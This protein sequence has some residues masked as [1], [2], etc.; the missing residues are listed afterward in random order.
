MIKS[1]TVTNH[2]GES[3]TLELTRPEQSGLV[4]KGIDGLGPVKANINNTELATS[5]I[6]LFNSARLTERNIIFDLLYME[7]DTI[8]DARQ[9][10]YKY[11]PIKKKIHIDFDTDNRQC[12][13]DGYVESN[14]PNIFDKESGAQIS[15]ICPNPYFYL[16]ETVQTE[17]FHGAEPLF[18]FPFCNNSLTEK[19][20]EFANI[21]HYDNEIIDYDGDYEAG[22]TITLYASGEIVDPVLYNV[23]QN[24]SVG[25]NSDTVIKLTGGRIDRGDEITIVTTKGNKSITLTRNGVSYNILAA[26]SSISTWFSLVKGQNLFA[27]DAKA[28]VQYMNVTYSYAVTYEGI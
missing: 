5:D 12:G 26:V 9:N 4:I 14:E 20:I 1:V 6:S 18:S 2:L 17:T 7:K 21:D 23:T 22:M 25:I 15:I 16:S 10:T 19:L 28:G 24:E 3:I 8:E 13:C 11:F 27:I